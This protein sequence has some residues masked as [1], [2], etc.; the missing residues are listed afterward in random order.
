MRALV[1]SLFL[2]AASAGCISGQ[3]D[4]TMVKDLRVLGMSLEP[5]EVMMAGCDAALLLGLAQPTD[6]GLPTIEPKLLAKLIAA[7]NLPLDFKALIGDPAGE[8]RTLEYHLRTCVSTG[9]RACN[10]AGEYVELSHGTTIGGELRL[11]VLPVAQL[12]P[13]GTPLVLSV[14]DRDGYKGLGGIKVPLVLELSSPD[15]Q[16][17]VFAQKLMVYS[18]Q[19]FP[20][21]EANRTPVLPGLSWAGDPWPADEVKQHSGKA[22]VALDPLDFT[23]LVESYVVPD[24]MLE[25]VPLVESWKINWMTTSG[26]MSAYSTGGT[27]FAGQAGRHSVSWLPDQAATAPA[28]VTLYFVV[29]DGRGGESWLTR[30]VHWTP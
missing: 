10:T 14:L 11:S 23:A 22:A 25:E 21:R 28:D 24:L 13:D 19:L 6:G 5:P 18:C 4:P 26:T 1:F 12:L 8:G 15:G 30:Q 3:D 2:V 9:D 20:D 7:A 29:R 17:H 16:E 27:D